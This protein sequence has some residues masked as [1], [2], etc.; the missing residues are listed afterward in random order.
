MADPTSSARG[1]LTEVC[2]EALLI[3][4]QLVSVKDK[5]KKIRNKNPSLQTDRDHNKY[6]LK[7]C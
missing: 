4:N 7:P 1:M 2:I 3:E 6:G 5:I